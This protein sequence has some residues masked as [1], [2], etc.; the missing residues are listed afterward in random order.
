M[1]LILRQPL[2]VQALEAQFQ[3]DYQLRTRRF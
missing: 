2:R 3:S 1:G